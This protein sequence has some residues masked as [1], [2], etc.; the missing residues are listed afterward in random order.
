MFLDIACFFDQ[1]NKR[2]VAYLWEDQYKFSP[3]ADIE[4]LQLLSLIKIGEDNMLQMH[5]QLRDLGRGIVRQENPKEPGKRS[6]LWGNEAVDM[7][8]ND[9][10]KH[11]FFFFL[12]WL[13]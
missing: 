3:E 12:F 7:L 9:Q 8:L 4:V 11:I 13:Y 1:K 10:V 5:D 2:I 6:R